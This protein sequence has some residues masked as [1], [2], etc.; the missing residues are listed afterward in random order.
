M[1]TT[2]AVLARLVPKEEQGTI[3]GISNSFNAGGRA[4]GPM[5][6]AASASAWGLRATFAVAAAL[7]ALVTG[8]VALVIRSQPDSPKVEPVAGQSHSEPIRD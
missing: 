7:F 5:L 6:G 3:Y 1:P 4:V 8:W 2:N